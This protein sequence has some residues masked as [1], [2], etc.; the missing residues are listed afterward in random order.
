MKTGSNSHCNLDTADSS[1]HAVSARAI[2]KGLQEGHTAEK[3]GYWLHLSGTG[4]LTWYDSINKRGG[5]A[6]LPEQKY[7]DIDG[8]DSILNLPDEAHHKDVDNIVQAAVSDAVRI[9]IICPPLIYG[10]GSGPVNQRSI[11]LP[12]LTDITLKEG[13][14]PYIG[15]GKTEWD[16]VH[17]DDLGDLYVKLVDATQDPSKNSNPEIFGRHGYFFASNGTHLFSKLAEKIAEEVK[18][19]GYKAEVPTKSVSLEEV[20]QLK[21][22]APVTY[23]FGRNSKGVPQRAKKYLGWEPK[24]VPVEDTIPELVQNQAKA[25][26]L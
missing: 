7:Y 2:A 14:A 23:S 22:F 11:Q 12:N 26:G 18:K 6:P 19:Q 1:D 8:I 5:E 25:L 4:I 13:F 21:G 24:G 20:P 9:A 3:P 16:N 15:A 17:I 10:K